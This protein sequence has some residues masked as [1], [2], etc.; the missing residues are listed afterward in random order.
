MSSSVLAVK[1]RL[2]TL[3]DAALDVPVFFAWQPDVTSD[4]CFLGRALLD[5]VD[6]D[7]ITVTYQPTVAE[8]AAPLSETYSIPVTL[9][10]W[11]LDLTPEG[12]EDAEAH[13]DGWYADLLD[14]LA[15]N[16]HPVAG[17]RLSSRPERSTLRR[18][19]VDRGWA[20]FTAVDIAVTATIT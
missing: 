6:R 2:V 5:P 11:R 20:C 1:R 10:S 14:V 3:L 16:P 15:A 13:I 17:V 19:P 8:V 18:I 9:W 12:A 7:E 4:C